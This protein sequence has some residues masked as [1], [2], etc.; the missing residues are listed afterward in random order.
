MTTPPTTLELARLR[1]E[2]ERLKELLRIESASAQ[3]ALAAA[4]RAEAELATE[5]ERLDYLAMNMGT[6]RVADALNCDFSRCFPIRDAIDAA[7]KT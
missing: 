5:R 6:P 3:H 2:V 4:E 1:A 7:M